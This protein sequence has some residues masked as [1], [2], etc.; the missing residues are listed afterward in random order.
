IERLFPYRKGAEIK[1]AAAYLT[2]A[3]FKEDEVTEKGLDVKRQLGH[4]GWAAVRR[5]LLHFCAVLDV[6]E[7]YAVET[8]E[9]WRLHSAERLGKKYAWDPEKG[10]VVHCMR[11]DRHFTTAV[12]ESEEFAP[13]L[14]PLYLAAVKCHD[15]RDENGRLE[16]DAVFLG[17]DIMEQYYSIILKNMPKR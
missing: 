17:R 1:S 4:P 8:T 10:W 3:L 9:F 16:P 15:M 11:A 7:E 2:T 5:N 6:P 13:V 12:L 14:G